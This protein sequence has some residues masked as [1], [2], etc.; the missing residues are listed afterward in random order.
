MS[1]IKLL[2]VCSNNL[3][4]SPT[5]AALLTHYAPLDYPSSA[6]ISAGPYAGS[7]PRTTDHRMIKLLPA[8]AREMLAE[9]RTKALDISAIKSTSEIIVLD[10]DS[11]WAIGQIFKENYIN[12]RFIR[13]RELFLD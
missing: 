8:G 5:A 11:A 10:E 4:C 12:R 9:H 2:F 3:N 13:F 7:T 6:V 1:K